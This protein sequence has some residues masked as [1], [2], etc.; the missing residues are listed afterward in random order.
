MALCHLAS[1]FLSLTFHEV[2]D[3]FVCAN[4]QVEESRLVGCN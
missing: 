2:A 3:G 4:R 1:S